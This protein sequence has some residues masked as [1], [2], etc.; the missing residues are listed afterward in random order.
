MAD[1]DKNFRGSLVF[2]FRK[3]WRHVKTIYVT[4]GHCGRVP[5][6]QNFRKFRF[7]IEWDKK[8]PETR[9]ENFGQPLEVVLFFSEIWKFRKFPIPFGISTHYEPAPVH[10]VVKSYKM[11][12]SRHSQNDLPQFEPFI[13][14]VSSKNVR[15]YSSG[16]LWTGRSEFPVGICLVCIISREKSS[17]VSYLTK[18]I[19]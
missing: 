13:D 9:F 18:I 17:Q 5:F 16:K 10:L 7:K 6:D 8:F 3:W 2:D 19:L 11:A 12:A 14:C 4:A 15:M 1:E